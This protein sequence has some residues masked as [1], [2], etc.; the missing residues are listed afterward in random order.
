MPHVSVHYKIYL[1]EGHHRQPRNA[2]SE[3]EPNPPSEVDVNNPGNITPLYIPQLPFTYDG[4]Q[5]LAQMM[6]WSVT[7]GSNGQVFSAGP[8]TQAVG[9]SP[10]TITAWYI[11]VGG[12]GNGGPG[13]IDDAFSAQKGDFID[14]TFV[15]VTSDP[16][17]TS[18]ANVV[19]IVPTTQA[20][21][22]KASASVASTNEPFS[23]WMSFGAGTANNDV[24][25]VPAN[26]VGIAIAI[27]QR[28]NVTLNGPG[29][30]Y[31]AGGYIVGGVAVDGG[32]GLVVNGVYHP[33][34]P[35]GPLV[36]SLVQASLVSLGASAFGVELSREGRQLAARGALRSIRAALPKIEKEAAGGE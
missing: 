5:A 23:K 29:R 3:L 24:L 19:G 15:T 7:D 22:L 6:F 21:T 30:Q 28:S 33:V 36:V 16:S 11:P 34:D 17:L 4:N 31:E 9:A 13:I 18:E 2:N 25:Q 12:D 8:L 10:L 26:S 14:D 27:Y 35:W 20:E 32:G 1:T